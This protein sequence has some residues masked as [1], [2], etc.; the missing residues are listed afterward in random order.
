[1]RITASL[2][3]EGAFIACS[4]TL[5]GNKFDYVVAYI[6][7][8]YCVVVKSCDCNGKRNY[9]V[10]LIMKLRSNGRQKARKLRRPS[11]LSTA[12]STQRLESS[13][14]AYTLLQVVPTTPLPC[15]STETKSISMRRACLTNVKK[16]VA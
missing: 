4:D 3:I 9:I 8:V 1:M 11:C 5:V 7:A 16:V 14:S 6:I 13:S 2:N 10:S 15:H 12:N